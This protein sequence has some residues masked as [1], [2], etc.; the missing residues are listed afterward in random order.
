M[1]VT[2]IDAEHAIDPEYAQALGV[3]MEDLLLSQPNSGEEALDIALN[4]VRC[5]SRWSNILRSSCCVAIHMS[6]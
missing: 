2:F 6:V 4:L 1:P 3:D 5:V